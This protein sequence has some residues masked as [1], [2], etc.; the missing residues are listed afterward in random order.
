M[1]TSTPDYR[2]SKAI[3][4]ADRL[5]MALDV[6]DAAAARDLVERL[7]DSVTFYKIGLELFMTSGYFDLLDWLVAR[8]KKVFVDLKFF[9]VPETVR[10]AIRALS[11]SG[12]TLAT[13]HGNQSIMEAAVKDK[14]DLKVLA[15]TALTSLDQGDLN[16]LGFQCNVDEL[17]LSRAR[18]ALET[19]ID[20]IVSSGLEAPM[21]RREL[22]DR[23]LVVTPGIRPVENRPADD[24]KRTVDVAQAFRNGADY[25]VV[26]RPIRQAA[27]PLAAARAIQ[28]TIAEVFPS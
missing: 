1:Q 24:Q 8:D 28:Q 22:G 19:G 9:D 2:S 3:T 7:E 4:P 6:A 16:D 12:A 11:G 21:I 25:I 26:G 23:L 18:R 5:I 27:D 14:G 15:V 20:G 17:V 13:I 10:S